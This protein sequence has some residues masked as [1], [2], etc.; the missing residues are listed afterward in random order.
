MSAIIILIVGIYFLSK[1]LAPRAQSITTKQNQTIEIS[2]DTPNQQVTFSPKG[3]EFLQQFLN[4]QG[5]WK[6]GAIDSKVYYAQSGRFQIKNLSIKFVSEPQTSLLFRGKDDLGSVGINVDP[7]SFT[8]TINI[9]PTSYLLTKVDEPW[10]SKKISVMVLTGLYRTIHPLV[11]DLNKSEDFD[12]DSFIEKYEASGESIIEINSKTSFQLVKEV[13]ADSCGNYHYD[14]G[15]GR[16]VYTCSGGPNGGGSCNTVADCLGSP[17]T[18]L[19]QC[20]ITNPGG[21]NCIE[22]NSANGFAGCA[23][24]NLGNCDNG[25]CPGRIQVGGGSTGPVCGNRICETASGETNA[26]CPADCSTSGGSTGG[27]N[28]CSGACFGGLNNCGEVGRQPAS[29]S[30][31]NGEMC[32]GFGGGGG[33]PTCRIWD[34]TPLTVQVGETKYLDL[35]GFLYGDIILG[36]NAVLSNPGIADANPLNITLCCSTSWGDYTLR[37]RVTGL[38]PGQTWLTDRWGTSA[39]NDTG[40]CTNS[41]LIVVVANST[42]PAVTLR[43]NGTQG[44]TSVAS[45]SDVTLDWFSANVTSCTASDAWSG[46]KTLNGTELQS[47]IVTNRIYTLTCTGPNGTVA[48]TVNV[49]VNGLPPLPTVDLK[50]NSSPSQ[51]VYVPP[52]PGPPWPWPWPINVGFKWTTT[53]ATSC[54]GVSRPHNY[55]YPQNILLGPMPGWFLWDWTLP[56]NSVGQNSTLGPVFYDLN[57]TGPGGR[58]TATVEVI[59][60]SVPPVITQCAIPAPKDP[61]TSVC[62][63]TPTSNGSMVGQRGVRVMTVMSELGGNEKIDI[64]EWS[65]NPAQFIKDS[66][67]PAEVADVTVDEVNKTAKVMVTED[68]QSLAIGKGGQNVRLA[69]KLTGWRIDI[70]STGTKSTDA[71]STDGEKLEGNTSHGKEAE[72]MA[73]ITEPTIADAVDIT[74]E[75]N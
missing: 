39:N 14:L 28:T 23:P 8:V 51:V 25:N 20:V 9:N 68:Q 18:G 58:S 61:P 53:N 48:D 57:C 2:S 56:V 1:K 74:E 60:G 46:S 16:T 22:V 30:C 59:P 73:G 40:S 29:G 27:G 55:V 41:V 26:S 38:V 15:A 44:S 66:L 3:D 33:G 54:V 11:G 31:S 67:S 63:P 70:Q 17:C 49:N 4:D 69:A 47:N 32:C 34:H 43:A 7:A 36:S 5:F 65:E 19:N 64:I 45:G 71:V 24:G 13:Y 6:E 35:D 52:I 72:T 12:F 75:Q 50:V 37:F 21:G 42:T 62:A 10:R